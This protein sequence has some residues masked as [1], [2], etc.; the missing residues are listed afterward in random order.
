[1]VQSVMSW[2]NGIQPIGAIIRATNMNLKKTITLY[3]ITTIATTQQRKII[4]WNNSSLILDVY[5]YFLNL[6]KSLEFE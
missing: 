3:K 4:Q 1:M 5:Y 2:E 6:T